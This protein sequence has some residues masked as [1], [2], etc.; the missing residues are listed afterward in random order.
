M[1]RRFFSITD[2]TQHY[3]PTKWG[4]ENPFKHQS[5]FSLLLE[6]ES[7]INRVL[8]V[9]PASLTLNWMEELSLWAPGVVARR[10]EGNAAD[11]TALYTL[12]IPL[13]VASY[14]HVRM[15]GMDRIPQDTFD[16][17]VLD[18]AQRIKDRNS[19]TS[20]ACRLLPRRRSWAPICYS[21]GK[22]TL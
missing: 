18:E 10:L 11:R 16:L 13:L 6:T 12:P 19:A 5:Q 15:D 21:A 8:V 1:G 2:R 14:E 20:L 9:A 17:V 22:S 7:D 3:W 4:S